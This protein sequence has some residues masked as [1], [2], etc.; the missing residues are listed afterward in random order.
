MS[1][2]AQDRLEAVASVLVVYMS[3]IIYVVSVIL[4][5]EAC[6]LILLA[7]LEGPENSWMISPNISPYPVSPSPNTNASSSPSPSPTPFGYWSYYLPD[8]S[9]AYQWYC[10]L[11]WVITTVCVCVCVL[12]VGGEGG[13]VQAIILVCICACCAVLSIPFWLLLMCPPPPPS[14]QTTTTGVGDFVPQSTAEMVFINIIMIVGITM[15]GLLVG[16][17]SL[18]SVRQEGWGG[19]R[20]GGEE[21]GRLT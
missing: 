21:V 11:Y 3:L 19:A 16:A 20:A 7:Y 9:A 15:F 1:G 8:E 2:R 4:N 17:L 10:A 14:V 18:V 5:F 13:A 12:R 6:M